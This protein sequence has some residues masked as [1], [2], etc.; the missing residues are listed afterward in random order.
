MMEALE[1][2]SLVSDGVIPKAKVNST[3][4]W[5][6][7]YM[8]LSLI[9]FSIVLLKILSDQEVFVKPELIIK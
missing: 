1:I 8:I 2:G 6:F 4:D 7:I 3:M 5:Q 9:V